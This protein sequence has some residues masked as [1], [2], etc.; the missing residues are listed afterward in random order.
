MNGSTPSRLSMTFVRTAR[1]LVVIYLAAL[2][3]ERIDALPA[4]STVQLRLLFWTTITLGLAAAFV[5]YR[6]YASAAA[7][8][9]IDHLNLSEPGGTARVLTVATTALTVAVVAVVALA[10]LGNGGP[11]RLVIGPIYGLL[12]ALVT[13]TLAV[14]DDAM[15][16][17]ATKAGAAVLVAGLVLGE[18][19]PF[20]PRSPD[21]GGAVLSSAL[22]GLT[23]WKE[24]DRLGRRAADV[25]QIDDRR[26]AVGLALLTLV[27]FGVY[28]HRL[29]FQH[30]HG[31]EHQVV[32][33]AGGYYYTGEFHL[34][35]WITSSPRPVVYDRA[36]PH[37][38]LVTAS[39]VLFGISEWS[40]RVPSAVAGVVTI[41]LSYVVFRYFTE[42]RGIALV[43]S[44]S[45][46]FSPVFVD[47]FRWTRMYAILVPSF[48]L[49]TYLVYRVLTEENTVDFGNGTAN[50]LVERHADF[51][52]GLG[53]LTLP[54]LVVGVLLHRNTLFLLPA[55]FLFAAYQYATTRK[56]KYLVASVVG[57]VGLA[58]VALSMTLTDRLEFLSTFLSW[59]ARENFVYVAYAFGVPLQTTL[60]VVL[61]IAG[62]GAIQ[63]SGDW[64]PRTKLTFLYLVTA[65][66]LVFLIFIGD[67]YSSYAYIVHVVPLGIVLVI[68]GYRA[69]V[70]SYRRRVVRFAF[71]GL[72]IA[73]V[74]T[75]I[76]TGAYGHDYRTLYYEDTQDFT[77]AYGTIVEH[78]DEGEAIFL[79]Y[80]RRYYLQDLDPGATIVDMESDQRYRPAKF[81][82]T[83]SRYESGWIAWET[84][85][86]HHIHPA[87]R[88]YIDE[89]FEQRHGRGVDDTGVTVYY[90]DDSMVASNDVTATVNVTPLAVARERG[91]TG[92][93]TEI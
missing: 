79:Q 70:V 13:V 19:F 75:P 54:L 55:G 60:G 82:R 93:F 83:V 44:A 57:T 36:W 22:V 80:P 32:A 43:A 6:P 76:Y 5:L 51:N 86:R 87:I 41:P 42:H 69:F 90:F 67:R 21:V 16:R 37:T 84:R 63:L 72:L 15:A 29:G 56:R 8:Y 23:I 12:V 52:V 59:F 91:R 24:R 38:V 45:L 71:V 47:F 65:F 89:H 77:T 39:Y 81:L 33:A 46:L 78:H 53:L 25:E 2:A 7:A 31:D 10:S 28:F 27:A 48:L 1:Y 3:L 88:E 35:N 92:R 68:A 62:F 4:L 30:L 14:R 50:A 9:A 18:W 74:V 20:V 66:S 26:Y 17:R 34:W 73:S 40:S 58:V 85:K 64:V 11:A 49:L 61:F